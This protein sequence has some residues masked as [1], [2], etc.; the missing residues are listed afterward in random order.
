M[1]LQGRLHGNNIHRESGRQA[2]ASDAVRRKAGA[3]RRSTDGVKQQPLLH[4]QEQ[5]KL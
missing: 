2:A 1:G 3:E 5:K 4:Q